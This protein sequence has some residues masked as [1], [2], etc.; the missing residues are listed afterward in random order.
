MR[1][2]ETPAVWSARQLAADGSWRIG[3]PPAQGRALRD[4]VKRQADRGLNLLDYRREDFPLGEL[5]GVLDRAMAMVRQGLGIA[6]LKDLPAEGMSEDEYRLLTW[7]V[8]LNLGV[9]VPQGKASHYISDVRDVGTVYK[10]RTGRGYSSNSALDFH[11]DASDV[12]LLSCL[13]AAKEGGHS[14]VSSGV[15]VHN[16]LVETAPEL[17]AILYRDFWFSRQG[18]EAPDE[19]P[20]YAIPVYGEK[21]GRLY[22]R[23]IRKNIT[24]AEGL[25]GVPPLRAEQTE[26]LDAMDALA[27][28]P[29]FAHGLDLEPGDIQILNNYT[30]LHSRTE[31]RDHDAPER[32]RLLFRL[33]LAAPGFGTLPDGW[34]RFYRTTAADAI[35]GGFRGQ[36]YGPACEAF[37]RRQC[38]AVG[39]RFYDE[40]DAA[41]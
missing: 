14:L 34:E 22:M 5:Q 40:V 2:H 26:A 1:I 37:E 39:M 41:A 3:I 18:E 23:H 20:A 25:P 13:R 8:G 9:A 12:V 16:R 29:D 7:A 27:A 11:T 36:N 17:A 21:E 19:Q 32:Q 35:R 30:A 38:A 10:S 24:F 31:F 15:R 6:L 28:D 4:L 33:W